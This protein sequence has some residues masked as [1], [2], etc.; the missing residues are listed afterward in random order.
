MLGLTFDRTTISATKFITV[1]LSYDDEILSHLRKKVAQSDT[2]AQQSSHNN[3][4]A[5]KSA[6]GHK[7]TGSHPSTARKSIH[8]TN[9][10]KIRT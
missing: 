1:S 2:I 9:A 7:E 5:I 3:Q 4:P 8:H 6:K 10:P